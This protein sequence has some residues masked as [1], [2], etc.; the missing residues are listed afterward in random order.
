[1]NFF[2]TPN[3]LQ[4]L[5]SVYPSASALLTAGPDYSPNAQELSRLTYYASNH[6]AKLTKLGGELE[7][8]VKSESKKARAG[9]IR[10]RASLLIS[11]AIFRSLTTECRHNITLLSPSLMA[12]LDATLSA[13][14]SDLEVIARAASVF[15]A[16][17]TYTDGHLIGTDSIL[18]KDYLAVLRS[19]AN[20]STV[21][22]KD[23]EARN[24]TRLIGFAGLTGALNSE[25]LY[26]D[27]AQFKH[28]VSIIMRPILTNLL[29]T[30]FGVLDELSQGIQDDAVSPYLAE[31][32]TRPI[33]ERRAASIHIHIDGENGPSMSDV[34]K[35][36]LRA[37]F[38]LLQH[39]NGSQ[40]GFIMRS[41]FDH[42]DDLQGWRKIEHCCW[43]A[44]KTAEWAQY[45]Y[46]YA[47]PTFLVER[48][49][50]GQ[51]ISSPTAMHRA[52]TT[53]VTTVFNSP[54][55]LINLSTS[56]IMS[57][58]I[59]L[60]SRRVSVSPLDLL[61]PALV[62]CIS[63]LGRHVYYSDQIQDLS[64]ELISRL[65]IIETQGVVTRSK[66]DFSQTRSEAI[67]VLIAGLMGLINTAN[68]NE[69]FANKIEPAPQ[70]RPESKP[71]KASP[72]PD[73]QVS[74]SSS[75]R[76]RVPTDIWQDSLSLL[77]DADYA[78]RADYA[79]A[80][81]FYL[82]E[83]MP[84]HGDV[85][86]D[87]D[88]THPRRPNAPQHSIDVGALL[89]SGDHVT[90]FLNA[91]HAYL[92]MLASSVSL[93][94]ASSTSASSAQSIA[95]GDLPQVNILPA[96]PGEESNL[97]TQGTVDIPAQATSNERRSFTIQAI[98]PRKTSVAVRLLE[99]VPPRISGS[100]A[101]CLSDYI[102]I[103]QILTRAHEE[104]PIRAL[105]S[106]IPMLLALQN[107][108]S[109]DEEDDTETLRRLNVVRLVIAK[110]WLCVGSVWNS[111]RL[112]EL[113]E[114][115][116]ATMP[117]SFNLPETPALPIGLYHAPQQPPSPDIP[118][119]Y[120][121]EPWPGVDAKAAIEALAS[122][123][124]VQEA[125]GLDKAG[126]IRVFSSTWTA[127]MALKDSI[128]KPS[129]DATLRGDGVSPLL[130][131]SPALMHI[132]NLS[133]QSL[134]R[135]TRGVGVSD[136]REALEGRSSMSNP[137]L[138]ARPGSISTLDH[139]SSILADSS[140]LTKTRSRPR[141]RRAVAAGSGEVRDVLN[142]LGIGKQNTSL[143]KAS[144]P[145][146]QKPDQR[147]PPYRP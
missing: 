131:I 58:L 124:S 68:R 134:A 38:S 70:S 83:E 9:N 20:A 43:F 118:D 65:L 41:S 71:S 23:H 105:L 130:K 143:L 19:F 27:S 109:Y 104:L 29:Q 5:N 76:T 47:I 12:A 82:S 139:S 8:K 35:A 69:E 115:A 59:N 87:M 42:L 64:G 133:L 51:D 13:L 45:Q 48:L 138:V 66:S 111:S 126:L 95:N 144:F 117:Q 94:L 113:V 127:E 15:N 98:R 84:K 136:L 89:Q 21:E 147:T 16:W 119:Q 32:R 80:L 85:G 56:D 74:N 75:R 92:Y 142:K 81:L 33:I 122:H 132:E 100:T 72:E 112:V 14:P 61:L 120:S 62:E 18:T 97:E 25:A 37:L 135:S 7:K 140:V 90:K 78:V 145:A 123:E 107:A 52:L 24:R 137:A 4:L 88:S 40:L 1:M 55:P 63:S 22:A 49:L 108:V 46:R 79:D 121:E 44:Q 146:L 116:L 103:L 54:T 110:V 31:F 28:Q 10:T 11:L 2:F 60:V 91:L 6:P 102:S 3:H 93:G 67:R 106:G 129:F 73:K 77:C 17:T 101:A 86:D 125:T 57:N 96:T 99:H 50:E 39:V 34:S 128:E 114:K 53:M 141:S 36:A 30:D 26:N